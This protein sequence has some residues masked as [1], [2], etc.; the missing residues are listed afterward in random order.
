MGLRRTVSLANSI[1]SCW[2]EVM[3]ALPFWL[4]NLIRENW[5]NTTPTY[6]LIRKKAQTVINAT[7]Y[8][9]ERMLTLG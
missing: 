9:Q 8:S 2:A 7:K 6:K 5:K 3:K 4:T 1:H